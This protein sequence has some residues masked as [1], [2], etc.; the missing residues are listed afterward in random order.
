MPAKK[1]GGLGRGL[2][3]IIPGGEDELEQVKPAVTPQKPA[4]STT[5]PK[6]QTKPASTQKKQEKP[7]E[8][9]KKPV[10]KAE[11]PQVIVDNQPKMVDIYEVEPDRDQP[12]KE[13]KEESLEELAQSIRQYGVLQPILVNTSDGYYK[14]IAG[15]RRWRAAKLAGVEK[16][17]ILVKELA[18]EKAFEISLIENIQRQDLNP[19][20]EAL[21]YQRLMDEYSL[22]QEEI[23]ERIGKSRSAVANMLRLLKLPEEIQAMLMNGDLSTGHAKV[24]SGIEGAEIQLSLAKRC[25]EEDWSVRQLENAVKNLSKP[26]KK[27]VLEERPQ[28]REVESRIR[29]ILGTKV[30]IQQGKRKG[31]IEIEYYSEEDLDRLLMLFGTIETR[32]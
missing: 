5:A 25:V 24:I 12:R 9:A 1:R 22:T 10:K 29:D 6:K 14:I 28:F 13:F 3:A 27:V 20:E 31:K 16:V 17:P 15:E 4:K 2:N 19:I 30:S 21:A 11:V 18:E 7:K 8:P 32:D 26:P 23:S